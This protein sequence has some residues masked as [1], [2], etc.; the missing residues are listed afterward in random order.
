MKTYK[1]YTQEVTYEQYQAALD[2]MIDEAV[3]ATR[4]VAKLRDH[5]VS[6][7]KDLK[8]AY[9][10]ITSALKQRPFFEILKAF[11]FSF[12]KM[13]SAVLKALGSL[14]VVLSDVFVQMEETGDLNKLKTKT[15]KAEDAVKKYPKLKKITGP[16]VAGFLIYQ[17]QHMAFTGNF[18][19]DFDMSNVIDALAGKYDITNL[20][21][22]P[23]ALAG[24]LKLFG[25][26]AIGISFPWGAIIPASLYLAFLYTAFLKSRD[27]ESLAKV[28]Q[29]IREIRK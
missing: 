24:M 2:G 15:M 22:S 4:L 19:D 3:R 14:N 6:I 5:L 8:I 26:V 23:S 25:G 13:A 16:M 28:R 10:N 9:D 11:G 29:K 20:L 27:R 17:W 1:Q 18:K 21:A 12:V 7:G